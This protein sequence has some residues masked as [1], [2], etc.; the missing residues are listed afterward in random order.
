ELFPAS[1]RDADGAVH[2]YFETAAVI[3]TLVV[4]G[5]VLE[6]GARAR[7]GDAI[8]ALLGLAPT[9]ARLVRDDGSEV[10]VPLEEVKP[11]DRLRVRPG[12]K[13]PVDGVVIEGTSSVDESMITGEPMPVTKRAG[14]PV[15]GATINGTGS[16]LMR[17][18]RV[19]S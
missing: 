6:L 12:E 8:R 11:G 7:T 1:M 2:L 19:G 9:T 15:T 16:L 14:D 17:A 18:E 3:I 13:I 10:D 4:L 5:E